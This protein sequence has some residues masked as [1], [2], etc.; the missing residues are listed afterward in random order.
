MQSSLHMQR[1]QKWLIK[2]QFFTSPNFLVIRAGIVGFLGGKVEFFKISAASIK[3]G[4]FSRPIYALAPSRSSYLLYKWLAIKREGH[5]SS[6]SDGLLLLV[7]LL[8]P[9][10]NLFPVGPSE[11]IPA[12]ARVSSRREPSCRRSRGTGSRTWTRPFDPRPGLLPT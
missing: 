12:E 3:P 5:A 6:P 11:S 8:S 4:S 1:V 7:L 10:G 9:R 2:I